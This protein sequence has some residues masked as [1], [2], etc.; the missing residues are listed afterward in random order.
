MRPCFCVPNMLIPKHNCPIHQFWAAVAQHTAPGESLFPS[1]LAKN[2]AGILRKALTNIHV[3]DAE[4]YSTH[5]FRKGAATAIL[6]SGA[7]LA[8]IMKTG[9]WVSGSFKVY[10]DLHH[11]EEVSMK[12]I[13]PKESPASSAGPP[14]ASSA[15]SATISESPPPKI[16]KI[17]LYPYILN[18]H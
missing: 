18:T 5:C 6:N 11:A 9:G 2:I 13:S 15:S 16:A 17:D 7:T 12:N 3:V 8:Q 10:L 4:R 14:S 1:L